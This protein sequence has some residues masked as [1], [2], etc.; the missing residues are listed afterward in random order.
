MGR[1]IPEDIIDRIR[2]QSDIVGIVSEYVTLKKTGQNY[3]GLCPFHTEKTPS[4]VVSPAKRI[5][6]CFGCGAGGNVFT[7]LMKY[8]NL[9]F[10]EAV[11]A[12]ANKL[13]IDL[14]APKGPGK[15][16]AGESELMAR[17]NSLTAGYFHGCLLKD[18]EA[19]VAQRY[20]DGRGISKE[21]IKRFNIGYSL[22]SWDALVRYLALQKIPLP[23]A[24]KAGLVIKKNKGEGFIDRFRGRIIFPIY[25]ILGRVI[26]FGG[27]VI[28]ESVPKYLNSPE[29]PLYTKGKSLYCIDRIKDAVNKEGYLIIVEGY[30]DAIALHQAGIENVVATLGTA[31]TSNHI[32]L[33]KRFSEEVLLVFDPDPAGI[34]AA[35][36]GLGGFVE[37]GLT[38]R[39]VSLPEGED[40]D[41]FIR[42]QGKEAFYKRAEM[43]EKLFNFALKETLK[44]AGKD[45]ESKVRA[46]EEALNLILRIPNSI[47]RAY[48]IKR[49]SE[50]LGVEEG[51]LFEEFKKKRERPKI[52]LNSKPSVTIPLSKRQEKAEEILIHLLLHN[53]ISP[54]EV[55]KEIEEEDFTDPRM[56]QVFRS[57]I[58]SFDRAGTVKLTRLIENEKD[59]EI[60]GI[61]T[62]L[63]LRGVDYDDIN[64]TCRDCLYRV[65]NN[66]IKKE[67]EE[68]QKKIVLA[69]KGNE[70]ELIT[71]LLQEKQRMARLIENS[72]LSLSIG[73]KVEAG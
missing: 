34:R 6:H 57:A 55:I 20:M 43:A 14:P 18:K 53:K 23:L 11:K 46:A 24:E 67:L 30:L 60:N 63:S 51:L 72:S 66:K 25:D 58:D 41:S 52:P 19:E 27:R 42:S 29:T 69:E 59:S 38:V 17:L 44:G 68:I 45:I 26:G 3:T 39:V 70:I 62:E 12:L 5:F 22:N 40:P 73:K 9:S 35:L 1:Y 16:E 71:H 10:S 2:D 4:L 65:K 8:N 36:R 61:I 50:T 48:Y 37:G 31:I 32:Q 47:E 15:E 33:I 13:G 49:A 21:T 7:F 28:D 64:K 54:G 56:R